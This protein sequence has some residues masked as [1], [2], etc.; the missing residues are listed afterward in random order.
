MENAENERYP[1]RLQREQREQ[2]EQTSRVKKAARTQQGRETR[3][4][5]FGRQNHSLVF[6]QCSGGPCRRTRTQSQ[7]MHNDGT[8][9]LSLESTV[10]FAK[11]DN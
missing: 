8:L 3:I 5:I 11:K 2:R 7:R 6:A 1:P 10:A 9:R 4:V